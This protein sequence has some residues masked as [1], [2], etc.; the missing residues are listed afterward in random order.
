MKVSTKVWKRFS[1]GAGIGVLVGLLVA[2]ESLSP[3]PNYAIE[4]FGWVPVFLGGTIGKFTEWK[5]FAGG[6]I[7]YGG[8]SGVF[9]LLVAKKWIWPCLFVMLITLLHCVL[10]RYAATATLQGWSSNG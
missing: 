1:F 3:R 5:I 9:A 6:A 4:F 10:S 2:Y 7:Y 8:I